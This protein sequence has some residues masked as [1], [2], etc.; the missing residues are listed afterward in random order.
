MPAEKKIV[1]WGIPK[2]SIVAQA[3]I[4]AKIEKLRRGRCD[5]YQIWHSVGQ[6][7]RRGNQEQQKHTSRMTTRRAIQ[8][9]RDGAGP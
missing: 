2:M 1:G 4:Q 8:K 7:E 3:H 6:G 5:N 9:Q